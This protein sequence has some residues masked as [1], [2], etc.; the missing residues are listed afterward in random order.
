MPTYNSSEFITESILSVINQTFMD[1]ELLVVDDCST[2]QTV[3]I[4][5]S[6]A[7]ENKRIKFFST[8]KN[9]GAAV[10][11]NLAIKKSVGRFIAFL[12]SDDLWFPEKLEQQIKFMLYNNYSFTYTFY[13]K[14][15][16]NG[17]KRGVVKAPLKTNYIDS[18]K[19]NVIGCLT[20]I[21]DTQE[22]GKMYMPLLRK[23]QDYCLWLSILKKGIIAYC[24]PENL[25]LYRVS[26]HSLSGNK[27]KILKY[28]WMVYRNVEKIGFFK[29]C[30]FFF[31]YS[32]YGYKRYRI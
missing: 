28:Q 1:W 16:K 2:D 15:D 17:S 8:E 10:A 26:Q 25:A 30:Y 27:F 32:F 11:R 19:T 21:Y 7:K 22:L 20:V 18:L 24:L 13:Q 9:S 23:R 4:I 5:S 31:F 3:E 14:I 12:D 6:Y 29:S